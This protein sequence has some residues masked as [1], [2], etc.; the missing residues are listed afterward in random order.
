MKL[1]PGTIYFVRESGDITGGLSNLVKIGLVEG[2]RSPF[3][4]L[5][6][7][8]TG[9]PR[10]LLFDESQFVSTE[11]VAYVEAQL[12]NSF[13][14]K[15]VSGEW[16][17]FPNEVEV[18]SA[19][20]QARVFA[21]N[22]AALNPVLLEAEKLYWSYSNSNI[23]EATIEL[24]NLG[25]RHACATLVAAGFESVLKEVKSSMLQVAALDGQDAIDQYFREVEYTTE[26]SFSRTKFQTS[27]KENK[28]L[29]SRYQYQ[30][31]KWDPKFENLFAASSESEVLNGLATVADLL[32]AVTNARQAHAVDDLN[33]LD[34]H[35]R[36][37]KAPFDWD[38]EYSEAHLKVAC[39]EN[40]G[41]EG[42]CTWKR[43]DK[44]SSKKF[45]EGAFQKENPD[46]FDDFIDP[47]ETRT[48]KIRMPFKK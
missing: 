41:I 7:H 12:H 14:D 47:G 34:L 48:K 28:D 38:V 17:K 21:A 26:P 1:K 36:V 9:N 4:R 8:Q 11:A 43:A 22:V 18:E 10:K 15:R 32:Q 3:D 29:Y 44:L 39:G 33:D 13:A 20:A 24:A 5:R 16:F 25:K 46:L 35:V 2:D 45:D 37:L 40:E 30:E 23:I 31:P 6:E 27:S 42:V 19:V